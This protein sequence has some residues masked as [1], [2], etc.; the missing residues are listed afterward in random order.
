MARRRA[1]KSPNDALQPDAPPPP[2]KK[3]KRREGALSA[4]SGFLSFLLILAL[5]AGFGYVM[6]MRQMAEPGPLGQDKVVFIPPGTDVGDIIATLNTEGV[7]DSPTLFNLQLFL[8]K[9]RNRM[10]AGEYLF[11]QNASLHDVMDTLVNG[12]QILHSVPIPEGLT[13]QQIVERLRDYDFL[14]GDVME[15]PKEGALL[16]D[17]YRVSRGMSRSDLL[18]KMQQAQDNALKQ[19]W[20]RRSPDLPLRT[21]FELVTLASI[22]E[23]ETGKAD[24]RPRVAGVFINRLQ[25]HM[26]LQSDPTIIYGIVGGKG[27]LGRGL[28]RSEIDRWTPYNTYAIDGL[29]PGPIANPGRAAMEAVA[30]PSRTKDLYFVADGTGGHIFAETLDQHS[31]NVTRW[32]QIER[33]QKAAEPP[34]TA[35]ADGAAPRPGQRSD[36]GGFAFGDIERF[37]TA[38]VAPPEARLQPTQ[39]AMAYVSPVMPPMKQLVALAKAQAAESEASQPSA[40]PVDWY[41][42]S[43]AD[44]DAHAVDAP[45]KIDPKLLAA[46][47]AS[48]TL[49]YDTQATAPVADERAAPASAA[50]GVDSYP[51]S[52]AI[53]AGQKA[54]AAK[55]GLAD[56]DENAPLPRDIVDHAP[57]P[58]DGPPREA[59]VAAANGE[60]GAA[61][62]QPS[63]KGHAFDASAGS[64]FDPLLARGW[65][66][67]AEQKVPRITA[68]LR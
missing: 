17:T 45:P 50:E 44:P 57:Q 6:L 20:A 30:N 61:P 63:R 68:A 9:N 28:L 60:A 4:V 19:I 43:A 29:P 12:R 22:V 32:R 48:P 23:K 11:K 65:D 55:Y 16:P 51:V 47:T 46:A 31:R 67:N 34:A 35:P 39:R 52:P 7:I 49:A 10:K 5:G 40:P 18:R 66:L 58:V 8:E 15:V 24:E 27:T 14:A 62:A 53:L 38:S 64:R 21:P 26:R 54:R 37:R 1:L 33:D 59:V 25:K 13:S 56:I 41:G 36:A 3:K 42:A 2:P